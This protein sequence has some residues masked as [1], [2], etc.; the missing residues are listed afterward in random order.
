MR[1]YAVFSSY[2]C[3]NFSSFIMEPHE[4]LSWEIMYVLGGKCRITIETKE[5]IVNEGEFVFLTSHI[6]HMLSISDGPPARVINLGFLIYSLPNEGHAPKGS[7]DMTGYFEE[8]QDYTALVGSSP[9]LT[10]DTGRLGGVLQEL[11]T[12]LE[13]QGGN[14]FVTETLF[15]LVL[16]EL[17]Q[18]FNYHRASSVYP[19][20]K[21][22]V[23]FIQEHFDSKLSAKLIASQVGIS[24]GYLQAL[25][26]KETGQG[27]ISY[28]NQLRVTK[29]CY[30][31]AQTDFTHTEIALATGFASRQHFGRIFKE[32]C[33]MTPA[34]YRKGHRIPFDS[35]TEM[36][37][38][39]IPIGEPAFG[40]KG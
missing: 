32:Q 12:E 36:V 11:I 6:P 19:Y 17:S 18:C 23:R 28:I 27:I 22:A 15:R 29:A 4:H 33:G 25:F 8:Y 3:S 1:H 26:K 13:R 14:R 35:N 9:L 10:Q 20:V 2:F 38:F 39:E 40:V 30:L 5:H 37:T 24:V 7:L 16:I 31:L 34:E 21:E